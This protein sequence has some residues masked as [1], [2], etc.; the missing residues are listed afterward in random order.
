MQSCYSLSNLYNPTEYYSLPRGISK[1]YPPN[2]GTLPFSRRIDP[3]QNQP[4]ILN[5]I[6]PNP[7]YLQPAHYGTLPI[8]RSGSIKSIKEGTLQKSTPGA[9]QIMKWIKE[10]RAKFKEGRRSSSSNASVTSST[11]K[12]PPPQG[13]LRNKKKDYGNFIGSLQRRTPTGRQY[14]APV[15]PN[16]S[17]PPRTQYYDTSDVFNHDGFDDPF[18]DYEGYKDSGSMQYNY[19]PESG[20]LPRFQPINPGMVQRYPPVLPE[21][22]YSI[23]SDSECSYGPCNS[24]RVRFQFPPEEPVYQNEEKELPSPSVKK[25]EKIYQKIKP[26]VQNLISPKRVQKEENPSIS[27]NLS[28]DETDSTGSAAV[29]H[30]PTKIV[31][32][33]KDFIDE[34]KESEDPSHNNVLFFGETRIDYQCQRVGDNVVVHYTSRKVTNK[35]GKVA[36]KIQRRGVITGKKM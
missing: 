15:Y 27:S 9:N 18:E 16:W 10:K 36:S 29:I 12:P 14:S 28:N 22:D 17:S 4:V 33:D 2:V 6:T 19:F 5:V 21:P 3:L 24:P 25:F 30:L 11:L 32:D 7:D 1:V 31:I 23:S 34:R 26:A 20:Y 8:K 13:I 35:D